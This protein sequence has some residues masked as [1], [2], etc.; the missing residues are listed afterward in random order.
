MNHRSLFFICLV[1]HAAMGLSNT[2]DKPYRDAIFW[3]DKKVLRSDPPTWHAASMVVGAALFAATTTPL[4]ASAAELTKKDVQE[5]VQTV[6]KESESRMTLKFDQQ[7]TE[8]ILIPTLGVVFS[9]VFAAGAA[10]YINADTT[11]K[12]DDTVARFT[13]EKE[14]MKKE[15]DAETETKA[16]KEALSMVVL[17]FTLMASGAAYALLVS[18]GSSSW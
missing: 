16:R 18:G 4:P 15:L 17:T 13:I 9:A 5:I 14:N 3:N 6:V 8:Y 1:V 12:L 11:R 7:R 2:S 10:S